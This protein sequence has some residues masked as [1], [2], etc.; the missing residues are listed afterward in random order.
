MR[1]Y[2]IVPVLL[3]VGLGVMCHFTSHPETTSPA[4][5]NFI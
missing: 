2:I 1:K 3:A 5:E 4:N